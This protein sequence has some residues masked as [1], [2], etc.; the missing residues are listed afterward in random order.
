M[1]LE[2]RE[3]IQDTYRGLAGTRES[4][5][6]TSAL[7]HWQREAKQMPSGISNAFNCPHLSKHASESYREDVCG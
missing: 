3:G 5:R 4:P 1:P 2:M 7:L 6:K